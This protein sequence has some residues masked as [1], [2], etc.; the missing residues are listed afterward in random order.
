V[1]PMSALYAGVVCD[2]A[3]RYV[4]ED[5]LAQVSAN[6]PILTDLTTTISHDPNSDGDL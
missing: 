1:L 4:N 5:P 3:G 2:G 6:S